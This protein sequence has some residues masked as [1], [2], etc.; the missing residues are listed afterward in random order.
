LLEIL[1]ER[2]SVHERNYVE[3]LTKAGLEVVRIDGVDITDNAV[4]ETLAAM[5]KGAQIIVQGALSYQAWGG[6]V[7]ILRRIEIPSA[8]G[9]WSYEVIDTK[10]ARETKAGTVL[11][12]CLYSDLLA[13]AQG[14]APE[15]MY[16]VAPWSEFEPQQY[17]F[18]DFSA[19]FR[20][21]K[22]SLLTS[23]TE[24]ET[25]ETYPDPKEHC[26]I[27]Q[28][29]EAC[30]KR[31][32]DD[33]H[34]CLV[35]GIS[36]LQINEL[37]QR[38]IATL[39]GLAGMPLPLDWK[40]DRGSAESYGR[41]REQARIQ[42][43]TRETGEE[44]FE[45]LPVENGFG[46]TRLPEPSEGDIF[47]DL[48]GDPFVGEHGLEYLFG[49]LF[50]GENLEP[51]YH[52]DWAFSRAD[53]K[54]AFENFVDFVMARWEKFPGL[55]IYHYAQYDPAALKRLMG[56]Y[57][58]REE[59]IDRMLRAKL[60][61]DLYQVV[62][63]GIRA[64]VESYSIKRLEPLYVFERETV[65]ADANVALANLQANLELDD[66]PSIADETKVVVRAYN[67]DDC[68]SAAS[69]RNWLETLRA[70]LIAAGTDVP[71]PVPGDGAPNEKITDWLIKI[72]GL[73]EKLTV[74]IPAD[75]EERDE[76]QQA[77][78]ILANILDWHRREDKAVWWELFRLADLSVEDLLDER[79]GLSGLTYVGNVG[80]TARA[81]IHRY[82][83]PPQ[84]TELRGGEDLRN[85]GGNKLGKIDS[86]SLNEYTVDIKKR[87]DSI[88]TH[89]QA[90]FAHTFVDARVM[91]DSL[92]RIGEYVAE[93]GLSGEG[94]YQAARDLLL[95]EAPRVGGQELH[96]EKETTVEAAVRLCEHLVGGILPI[97]G[98]P[99]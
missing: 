20:K 9:H 59:E 8:I 76:E 48:E 2:G 92:V 65:L 94:P 32:R 81:P 45:V 67:K 97:Q 15:Y 62:R 42:V 29:R 31:R 13:E 50:S 23:L 84:E 68:S 34:L 72:R 86:I 5:K 95:K 58:T 75:P 79:A 41:I 26:D 47:L 44:K 43:E 80:G 46:L 11:Q 87:Q 30:D 60:F 24:Q 93:H 99:G 69:L 96:R 37:K 33:D 25:E 12:L 85:L 55:H 21:V 18:A 88:G 16:V 35:A 89:P 82:K 36:K 53:E 90:V 63:H 17:R 19:Y 70:K 54:L 40:P 78:W 74:D 56:R 64:G 73:I 1:W 77:R 27:C 52:S 3:H 51:E 7:D 83:F 61:V 22:R 91:A 14:M 71:R 98:P 39:Q 6:R 28:W 10:L 49:C 66:I 4:S 38:G 57:A